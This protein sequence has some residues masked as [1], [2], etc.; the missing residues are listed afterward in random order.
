MENRLENATRG[1]RLLSKFSFLLCGMTLAVGN[2]L[3]QQ[4]DVPGGSLNLPVQAPLRDNAADIARPSDETPATYEPPLPTSSDTDTSG[5]PAGSTSVPVESATVVK[6]AWDFAV[7]VRTSV[8][9]DDNLFISPDNRLSDVEFALTPVVALGWG[10]VRSA[11]HEELPF[12]HRFDEPIDVEEERNLI[13]VLYAP[14]AFF[15]ADH[16]SENSLDQD[17]SVVLQ[18]HFPKLDISFISRYQTLSGADLDLGNRA[19]R[20]FVDSFLRAH[21]KISNKF[22]VE[23][24]FENGI[25]DYDLGQSVVS[26]QNENFLDYQLRPK[27]VLG[28]GIALGRLEY[29]QGDN[30]VFERALARVVYSPTDKISLKARTGLEF[31]QFD[32]GK[33]ELNPVFGLGATYLPSN[34]TIISLEASRDVNS[35]AQITRSSV[36]RTSFSIDVQQRFHQFIYLT[37]SAGYTNA[38]YDLAPGVVTAGR[39]DDVF[40]IYPS[41]GFDIT[42]HASLQIG[43]RYLR[44]E[45]SL[46]AFTFT[47]NRISVQLNLSF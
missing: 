38:V 27:T 35:T 43:Y 9:Y 26:W 4:A 14:T 13:L 42:R 7:G 21:Y 28:V 47:D 15:F 45:S 25:H 12:P 2:S 44:D 8:T 16:N 32:S 20:T 6:P 1:E 18:W 17:A 19:D 22:S 29:D 36:K 3:A 11:M 39:T 46:P 33:E 34:S 37:L 23:T 30:Q 10:D 24:R 31:R 40:Y 5:G 41:I